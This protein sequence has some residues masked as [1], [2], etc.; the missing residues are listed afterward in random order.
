MTTRVI[1]MTTSFVQRRHVGRLLFKT[2]PTE[3]VRNLQPGGTDANGQVPE[4]QIFDGN[5]IPCRHCV[6]EIAEG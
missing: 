6:N 2:L 4:K 3:Q 1:C 5:G